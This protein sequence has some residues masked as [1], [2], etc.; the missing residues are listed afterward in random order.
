MASLRAAVGLSVPSLNHV[1]GFTCLCASQLQEA[2]LPIDLTSKPGRMEACRA[3][4][5]FYRLLVAIEHKLPTLSSS[6]MAMVQ[7]VWHKCRGAGGEYIVKRFSK[8]PR[9]ISPPQTLQVIQRQM[10]LHSPGCI[11]QQVPWGA[12]LHWLA[13][14]V[15]CFGVLITDKQLC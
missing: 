3:A 6:Q 12:L 8:E 5:Q 1:Q 10:L 7:D 4:V 15:Q 2:S 13:G 14:S 11:S 9:Y